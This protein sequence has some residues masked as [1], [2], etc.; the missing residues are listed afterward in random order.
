MPDVIIRQAEAEDAAQIA[1]IWNHVIDTTTVTFTTDHKTVSGLQADIAARGP[2][3]LVAVHG[4]DVLGF[5]TYFPFRSGPGYVRTKE[6]S[7]QI[8]PDAQGSGLGRRLMQALEKTARAEDVHVL[9]AAISGENTGG[10][11]FH[12]QI[13]F[14]HVGRLP[15]VGQKFGRVLDM[16]LMQ[17]IL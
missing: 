11:A 6:H 10:M 7:V 13:G 14:E 3:F 9:M 12:A 17:K 1:T 5:A 2:A 16:V 8:V 15:Q 4:S